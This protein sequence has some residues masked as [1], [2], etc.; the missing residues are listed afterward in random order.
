MCYWSE[1]TL[2]FIMSVNIYAVTWL[3]II[4]LIKV[5]KFARKDGEKKKRR[6][7]KK[8]KMAKIN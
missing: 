7:L 5:N 6:K 2:Y 4:V 3:Y 8:K 1:E